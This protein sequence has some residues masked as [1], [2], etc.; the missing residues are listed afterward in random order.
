HAAETP[1]LVVSK[2][3]NG[4][5]SELKKTAPKERNE[6]M[7]RNLVE[8]YI[9]PAIDQE[10]IAMGAL[11]KYWRRATVEERSRFIVIFRERQLRTYQGAFKAFSGET[12]NFEDT[13]FSPD[14]SRAIVKG[15]F[16]QDSGNK[17]PVDFRLFQDKKTGEW[18]VYDAVI[19]GLSMVKTYRTQLSE[20]LQNISIAQLLDELENEPVEP[21]ATR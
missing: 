20:R 11:G 19:S 4:I 14:G 21:I 5:I 8:T 6:A 17:V 1:I 10:K 18:R 16:T 13:Q 15:E 3:T 12:L 2:A 9:L 7:V